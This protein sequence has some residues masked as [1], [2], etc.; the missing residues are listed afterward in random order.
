M[1]APAFAQARFSQLND[2]ATLPQILHKVI[3]LLRAVN[4]PICTL[5]SAKEAP[6]FSEKHTCP[7]LSAVGKEAVNRQT[8]IVI[9]VDVHGSISKH[10]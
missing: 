1:I 10:H 8:Y 5:E 9:F 4:D 7:N 3:M 2:I 6:N